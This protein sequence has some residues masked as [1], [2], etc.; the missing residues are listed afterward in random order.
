MEPSGPVENYAHGTSLT[1]IWLTL[2]Y[3]NFKKRLYEILK[4]FKWLI[5]ENIYI[6]IIT[7]FFIGL[8]ILIFD[9]FIKEKEKEKNV[10]HPEK[11]DRE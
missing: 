3:A 1:Q 5:N 9:I 6:K 7:I 8:L 4:N 2:V 11:L 10:R